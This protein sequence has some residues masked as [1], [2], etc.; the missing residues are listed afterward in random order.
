MGG[1][2]SSTTQE[3]LLMPHGFAERLHGDEERMR[4]AL[5]NAMLEYGVLF[6]FVLLLAAV[7]FGIVFFES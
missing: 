4:A 7:G 6:G 5:V 3:V 2:I 1:A